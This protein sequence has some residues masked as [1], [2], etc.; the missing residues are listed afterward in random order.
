MDRECMG[1]I[2]NVAVKE[3]SEV[4]CFDDNHDHDYN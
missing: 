4:Y 2:E 3:T 1:E